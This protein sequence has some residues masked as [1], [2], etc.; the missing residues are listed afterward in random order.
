[1]NA[2]LGNLDGLKKHLLAGSLAEEKSFDQVIQDTGLGAGALIENFCNRKFARA[3]GAQ[4]K[5][6]ADRASFF[7]PRYPVEAVTL[8]EFKLKESDGWVAQDLSVIRSISAESGIVYFPERAD[9]GPS[10]GQVRFT[11]TGGYFFEQLEPDED[12]YP[13]AAPAGAAA[14]PA[15]VRFAW[16]LQCRE[17]WSKLD[18]LGTGLVDK[19]G[20]QSGTPELLPIVKRMLGQY[21]QMNPV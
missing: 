12:G 20:E 15:D 4:A 19:P 9:A 16:L 21:V 13:S 6:Q 17:M 5:F 10:W 14:L 2:G 3:V 18:K 8:V 11:F 1:M 7:L